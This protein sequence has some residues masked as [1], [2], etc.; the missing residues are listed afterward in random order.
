MVSLLYSSVCWQGAGGVDEGTGSPW[1]ARFLTLQY[2][3]DQGFDTIY[4]SGDAPSATIDLDVTAGSI[5]AIPKIWACNSSGVPGGTATISG[6]N[7]P[8]TSPLL[9]CNVA[10]QFL[11]LKG[12]II[13]GATSIGILTNGTNAVY[14]ILDSCKVINSA[15]HGVSITAS[16][17]KAHVSCCVFEGN[18]GVNWYASGSGRGTPSHFIFNTFKG[19]TGGIRHGFGANTNG[20]SIENCDFIRINGDAISMAAAIT[21]TSIVNTI[22]NCSFLANTGDDIDARVGTGGLT[23]V[24][25]I[26]RL[27]GGYPINTNGGDIGGFN[28]ISNCFSSPT[29]GISDINGGAAWGRGNI[30]ADP[31]F[32]NETAGSEDLNLQS[33]SPCINAGQGV[34]K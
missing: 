18:G 29:S 13:D 17:S 20:S 19:G 4:T 31:L 32:V 28:L 23:I 11:W 25:N 7:L 12:L 5:L 3:A 6:T 8:A 9:S 34:A 26:F 16:A 33:T 15:S 2:A 10:V 27:S 30:S 24:N 1:S 22:K 14:L 21:G